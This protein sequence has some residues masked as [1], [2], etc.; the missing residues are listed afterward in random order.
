MMMK[1]GLWKLCFIVLIESLLIASLSFAAE[2]VSTV[3]QMD[4]AETI[5]YGDIQK[6][7]LIER[8]NQLEAVMFG[9]S[10]PGSLAERQ[11]ALLNYLETGSPEQPSMLF[12]LAIAEWS[13]TQ[14]T[15]PSVPAL[16]RLQ[17]LERDLEGVIQEGKPI[18]MRV[19]RLLVMLLAEP[20]THVDVEISG[21][22]VIRA[23]FLAK[24]GPGV[25]KVGDQASLELAEDF[26][27]KGV[28]VAPA[29]NR[30]FA[31]VSDVTKP[32]NFG[33]P[34]GVKLKPNS[35]ELLGPERP[36][37]KIFDG[38]ISA[39]KGEKGIIG[40]VGASTAGVILLGPVGLVGG[41]F[42]RGN[43]IDIPE[44][45]IIYF[46][47][48]ERARV[49]GFPIPAGLRGANVTPEALPSGGSDELNLTDDGSF[50]R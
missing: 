37:I 12:K 34:G 5:V 13:V 30:V 49:S 8:L 43:S 14:K 28:L 36:S 6:G 50:E 23:K 32:K 27:V 18:A 15:S 10:L 2:E 31:E 44:G 20:V 4:K 17:K 29:G 40:A 46:Q 24:L 45:S 1:K 41:L 19:E 7:G 26:I 3:Q 9:R 35:L 48:T 47:P 42:I 33:I 11:T 25:S 38:T 16:G 22:N 21:D 39:D